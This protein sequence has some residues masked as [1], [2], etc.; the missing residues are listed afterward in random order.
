MEI[1]IIF[2][3]F[4]SGP[5]QT[6][7]VKI[8]V[9]DG[10]GLLFM[11]MTWAERLYEFGY[12]AY[13]SDDYTN[14]IKYLSLAVKERFDNWNAHFYLAISYYQTGQ[15]GK[16]FLEFCIIDNC[17]DVDAELKQQANVALKN[18]KRMPLFSELAATSVA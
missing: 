5:G 7:D 3:D 18:L 1:R 12:Q 9:G 11:G 15:Y 6:T 2:M 8:E 4:R 13:N 10:W 14:A 16:A 17:A